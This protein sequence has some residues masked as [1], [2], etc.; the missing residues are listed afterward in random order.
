[1]MTEFVSVQSQSKGL[2]RSKRADG[3]A[4]GVSRRR[5]NTWINMPSTIVAML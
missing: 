3:D 2:T 5:E 4:W 1:M